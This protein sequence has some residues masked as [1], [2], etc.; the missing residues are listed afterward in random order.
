MNIK[1]FRIYTSTMSL[2][3][4]KLFKSSKTSQ[5]AGC[6]LGA[7]L[8]AAILVLLSGCSRNFKCV[9]GEVY[10]NEKGIW[11]RDWAE[12]S[13]VNALEK[14]KACPTV[15]ID[16]F[17]RIRENKTATQGLCVEFSELPTMLFDGKEWVVL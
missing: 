10:S 16:Q 8:S 5:R 2:F 15:T 7:F 12:P 14:V 13:C 11:I 17:K 4:N 6:K 9:N 3:K 1:Q